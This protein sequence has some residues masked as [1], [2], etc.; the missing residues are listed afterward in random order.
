MRGLRL[1][2]ISKVNHRLIFIAGLFLATFLYSTSWLTGFLLD[3]AVKLTANV[4]YNQMS[5]QLTRDVEVLKSMTEKISTN[6]TIVDILERNHEYQLLTKDDIDDIMLQIDNFETLLNTYPFAET[7]NIV[8]LQGEYLF[9]G[10][11]L[12]NN[13]ILPAR[14]WFKEEYL[15]E[16]PGTII[17]DLHTDYSTGREAIGIVTFIY[18]DENNDLLGAVVLDVFVDKLVEYIDATFYSGDLSASLYLKSNSSSIGAQINDSKSYYTRDLEGV[19][20]NNKVKFTF[21]LDSIKANKLITNSL[22]TFRISAF[23][24]GLVIAVSLVSGVKLAFRPAL[25]AIIKLK[26]LIESLSN[27][28]HS[29]HSVDEFKQLELLASSLEKTFDN[30]IQSLIYYDELTSLPNRKKLALLGAELLKTKEPFALVFVDLNKFKMINDVYGHTMGDLLLIRF[31]EKMQQALGNRGIVTRYSGDEFILI[32]KGY[33]DRSEF[34][35]YYQQYIAPLFESPEALTEEISVNI[36]FSLGVAVYPYDGETLEELIDK[37][38]FMMY[39]H[40]KNKGKD[41]VYFFED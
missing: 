15:I 36:E 33:E 26:D 1:R 32:Y 11:E 12:Y 31:G 9:T 37:S 34:I 30:K 23:L 22:S 4:H 38:D 29:L 14:P 21:N 7:L 19:F 27:E 28:E 18:S 16:N 6:Q 10:G 41:K 2:L 25:K 5:N 40:K 35:D 8:S 20:G 24:T 39:K 17:T 3:D 13:F